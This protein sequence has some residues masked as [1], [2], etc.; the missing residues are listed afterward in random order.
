MLVVLVSLLMLM[1]GACIGPL[2]VW[3]LVLFCLVVGAGRGSCV[4]VDMCGV[5]VC[6]GL[7]LA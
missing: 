6:V 7:V 1:F 2:L 5:A 3:I 4:G